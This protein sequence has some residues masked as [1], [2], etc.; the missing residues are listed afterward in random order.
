ME[1]SRAKGLALVEALYRDYGGRARVL[2]GEGRRA[3]GYI[4]AVAPVEVISAAGFIPVRVKGE[5]AEAVTR[6]PGMMETLVCPYVLSA[7]DLALKGRYEYLEGMV[8]PHTCD[9]VTRTYEVWKRNLP[10]PYYH[11][12]NVPHLDDAPSLEF[13]TRVL[14]TFIGSLE[15]A[16]GERITKEILGAAVTAYNEQRQ[17]MRGL[18]E[19]RKREK[20]AISGVEM[21]KLLTAVRAL[22]V[23]ESVTLIRQVVS[24]VEKR[25]GRV[26]RKPTRVMLVGD[27]IDDTTLV[28][29]IENTGAWVVMDDIS[30]GSKLY[31]ADV[32]ETDDPLDGIARYYL[33][34][35]PLPTF[36]RGGEVDY[37]TGLE[38]RFGYLRRFISEFKVDGVVLLVYRN[39]DPYGLEVPAMVS[40]VESAGIPVLYVEDDYSASSPARLKTRIEA[41]LEILDERRT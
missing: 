16:S 11:F 3:I 4:S 9:S 24:E 25:K 30:V 22:P 8:V 6:A 39:C 41:F 31:L 27:Q 33:K 5:P 20:P 12:L 14:G 37:R 7:F 23:D 2:K 28:E 35:V 13:F 18:Y 19:L 21:M 34:K 40:Y 15:Q 17:A 10:L 32:E 1:R 36:V 26:R 38:L 29:I